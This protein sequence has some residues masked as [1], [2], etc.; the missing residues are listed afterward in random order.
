MPRALS[1]RRLYFLLTIAQ[2]KAPKINVTSTGTANTSGDYFGKHSEDFDNYV[3][4]WCRTIVHAP[5]GTPGLAA[6]PTPG[7]RAPGA[8]RD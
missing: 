4:G 2:P 8:L 1:S 7:C 3:C 6:C 5:K